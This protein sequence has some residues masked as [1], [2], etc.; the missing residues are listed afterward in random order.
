MGKEVKIAKMPQIIS[1]E[2]KARRSWLQNCWLLI[3][4][5]ETQ[6]LSLSIKS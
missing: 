5:I 6:E 2:T 1:G 3:I 4:R